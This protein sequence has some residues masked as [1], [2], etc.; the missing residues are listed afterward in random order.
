MKM[1]SSSA[2]VNRY[3]EG[4]RRFLADMRSSAPMDKV[5]AEELVIFIS[6]MKWV[7]LAT[8]IG[9]I[10]G[11]ATAGFL[12]LLKVSSNYASQFEWYF[13][14]LPVAFFVSSGLV[15]WLAPD[16]EG[17]GTEKVIEAVHQR[18]GRINLAVVPVKLAATIVTIASG[19]SAGKEGP[20]AQIGG[21]LASG[22]A[23]LFGFNDHDRKK[24]VIC[25]ISAGFAAVFGTPIAGAIFGVEVL[26]AGSILYD[27]LLPSFI[28]GVTGY[29]IA[30]ALGVSYFYHQIDFVP[31]FSEAFFAKI[32]LAG[33]VFGLCSLTL[34]LVLGWG[35]RLSRA[36]HIWKPLKGLVGG[37]LLIGI[38][39]L[40]SQEYLGLGLNTI[41]SALHG[42]RPEWYSFMMKMVTTSVT[43][44]FGGSGGIVTPIF[45]VGATAGSVF[46]Q[47]LNLD[48]A[49]FA[50]IGMVGLLAGAAN[51]PIAASILAVE[52]FGPKI[53]PYATVA[54]VISFLITGHRS[55]YPSQILAIRKSPSIQVE[56]GKVM[57]EA[58]PELNVRTR[59]V[60]ALLLRVLERLRGVRPMDP[61]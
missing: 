47:L 10:V 36:I 33:V 42:Q 44:N 15:M 53:A 46:A 50:A 57:E 41:Q 8:V 21:G 18:S 3:K 38:T 40:L 29:Q 37:A 30:H 32:V 11:G 28:S 13:L 59:S 54:C 1:R 58:R 4:G 20:C 6:V 12:T 48:A 39:L 56:V 17:H 24:L 55:V 26:F 7:A 49:T 25:G 16:A 23:S 45:F 35:E 22:F 34:I 43:L 27:V 14:L 61:K 19:G 31:V 60:T 5:L 9:A 2:D 52:L 51:T